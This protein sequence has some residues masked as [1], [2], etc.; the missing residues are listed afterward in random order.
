MLKAYKIMQLLRGE[1]GVN[2]DTNHK[3]F[4]GKFSKID[5]SL[6]EQF[7]SNCL[8]SGKFYEVDEELT[9]KCFGEKKKA[10]EPKTETKEESENKTPETTLK[11]TPET[12]EQLKYNNRKDKMLAAGFT[13]ENDEF[14]KGETKI[15][16]SELLGLHSVKYGKLIKS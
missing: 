6:A 11:K 9:E 12:P 14:I 15:K 1:N 10:K 2:F 13:F 5:E 8:D 16:A 7:N 4:T 3:T